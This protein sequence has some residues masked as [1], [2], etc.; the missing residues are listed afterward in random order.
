MLHKHPDGN[1]FYRKMNHARPQVAHGDGIYLYDDD[2]KRYLDGSGGPLVT[3]VGHGHPEV[4]AAIQAQAGAVEYA[5]AIM[6][7]SAVVETYSTA[8]AAHIPFAEPRFFYLSSGSEV[9]ETAIKLARQ[10]QIARGEFGR[11]ITIGRSLSYHGMTLGALSISGRPGLRTP[12]LGM[13]ANQPHIHHPYPYRDDRSGI[14][15]ADRL[16]EAILAYG[17][18]NVSAFIA[19]PI[20][21]ASLGA[22]APPDDYWPRVREICDYYGV[23]LIAD[24]V[25]VG[26]G[27]TGQW[28]G[29]NHWN[30]VPDIMVAS[31]GTAGGYVPHG[32]A[33]AKYDDVEL[34]R[35]ELG[36]FNHGGTFSHH[37]VAAAAALAVL[38]IIE[39]DN[40]VRNS[41]EMGAYLGRKLREALGDH[42]HVGD[43]RGRGL[44]WGIEFVADRDTKEPFPAKRH[45]A[46]DIW[47][48]AFDRGLIIYYSQGC[49]DGVNGD[50]IMVGPPL[51]INASQIDELVTLLA[52]AIYAELPITAKLYPVY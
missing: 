17:P 35:Q 13:L 20:S 30:V 2:G 7:T 8:M 18:E 1:V 39:R 5:H 42:P 6:F 4:V 16:E 12:Y 36:D 28:W 41:A 29:V 23:L 24:E 43:I 25:L 34:I 19:E 50:V 52:D 51:I 48:R 45:L 26:M 14:E 32:F 31:K 9:V 40:L 3:N 27:R 49:A 10:I 11:H 38:R 46:W 33:A 44:F 37:P 22:V 15:L 47:Q 21:G